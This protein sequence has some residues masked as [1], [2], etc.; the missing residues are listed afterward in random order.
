MSLGRVLAGMTGATLLVL[1]GGFA[2]FVAQ[3]NRPADA[4]SHADGLVVLTGGAERVATGL[5]LLAAGRA[6]HLLVSGVALKSDLSS[7]ARLSGLDAAPLAQRVEL[8]HAASTTHGNADETAAWVRRHD[9]HSLIVVTGYYHMPRALT[10]LAY[11]VPEVAIYRL[12]VIPAILRDTGA[13]EVRLTGLRLLAE[14]YVKYLAVRAGI[15]RLLP[16]D[17]GQRV[18]QG[19]SPSP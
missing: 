4:P 12:P 11:A 10:E 17:P 6:D 13:A 15:T 8:G 3:T 1:G 19:S 7:L 5:H 2:W 14:E 16:A 18:A 9:I